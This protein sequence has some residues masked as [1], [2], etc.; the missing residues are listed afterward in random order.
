MTGFI[1][2][3][4]ALGDQRRGGFFENDA[5]T[6]GFKRIRERAGRERHIAVDE[7]ER[8]LQVRRRGPS[9]A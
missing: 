1:G 5:F 4:K 3:P 6:G 2:A 9:T 7:D 8:A